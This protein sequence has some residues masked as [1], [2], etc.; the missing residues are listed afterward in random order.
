MN[1]EMMYLGNSLKDWLVFLSIF[2]AAIIVLKIVKSVVIVKLKSLSEKTANQ[3]D[4]MV[5]AGINSIHWP[6][7]VFV[8]FYFSLEFL[9][10]PAWISNWSYYIF[11]IAVSYYAIKILENIIEF[12][13]AKMVE[14]RQDNG[15]SAG[16]VKLME[17]FLKIA[18]WLSAVV[19]VLS[20][21]GY[22]VTSLIAGLGIGGIAVALALQSI[23]GDLFSSLTI[24]FDKPFK[25]GDFIIVG[26]DMGVVKKIGIKTTRIQT[27]QGQELVISNSELTSSRVNNYG[28]MSERRIP[29]E[30]GVIYDTPAEKLKKIPGMMKKIIESQEKVRF[31]RAHFR[32]FSD[33]SLDFEVVY[34]LDTGDYNVFM[35]T[36]Q[37]INLAMVER[38]KEE[39]IEFAFPTQTIHIEK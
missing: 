28:K 35:D 4:D 12:A 10:V 24:Y 23:L 15:Q 3:I 9:R 37:A 5:I 18:L 31:D 21:M 14:K 25:D 7:F 16:I 8:S 32:G 36:Q 17:I 22:N 38:F 29:F 11:L 39:K 34:Y 30:F 6:F 19:L 1:L 20:N 13:G 26:S 33:S 27:L 2:A